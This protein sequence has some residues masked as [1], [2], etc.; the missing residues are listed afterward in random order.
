MRLTSGDSCSEQ[1]FR[2]A[3][4]KSTQLMSQPNTALSSKKATGYICEPCLGYY[5]E[6]KFYGKLKPSII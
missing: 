1:F 4:S 3:F 2:D 6:F 5:S